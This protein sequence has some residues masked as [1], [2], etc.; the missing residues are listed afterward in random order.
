MA[1]G[2]GGGPDTARP[3]V[4]LTVLCVA[5]FMLTLDVAVA[6][7]ALPV[8]QGDLRIAIADLQWVTVAYTL[9][10]GGFLMLAGRAAD[11]VGRRRMFIAGLSLFT[12]AS[13]GCAVS[14]AD[15]HL[16]VSR[17]FQGVGAAIVTPVALSLLTT[18]FAEGAARNRAMGIW[19]ALASGG[20]IAGQVLGGLIADTLG[21][22]WIFFI[23]LP[24]GVITAGAALWV[25]AADR[26]ERRPRLDLPG[27]V[28][29]T[30]GLILLVYAISSVAGA[31]FTPLVL[32]CLTASLL[33]LAAFAVVELRSPAPLVRFGIFTNRGVAVGNAVNVV[34][35]AASG[36]VIFFT[37]LYLQKVLGFTPLTTGIAFAPVTAVILLVSTH[38]SGLM[39]RF[40]A[41]GLLVG[42]AVSNGVGLL[43][44]GAIP[45]EGGYLVNVLPGLLFVGLGAALS[46]AP[47]MIVGT[48]GV[49]DRD[50]GLA[51]GLISTSQ[52]LGGALGVAV[53]AAVAAAW[54]TAAGGEDAAA[55]VAG[56]RAGYL[57]ALVLP[58]LM[59]AAVLALRGAPAVS[60]PERDEQTE[61]AR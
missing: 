58:V 46:F 5:Q 34:N 53:F 44:F 32:G 37:A 28:T 38:I 36:T 50:Q 19:G 10:Y 8:I 30:A 1:T 43:W 2:A 12:A 60:G 4:A 54:T 52:Q 45:V 55:L 20:A 57:G 3:W 48:S 27:A 6:S 24:V 13:L 56:Y 42:G 9:T 17:A 49:Q 26:S 15:W 47:S 40:G 29:L 41:R 33:L 25:F 59:A 7:V 31:G 16:F 11:L 14:Q 61:T 21:W 51:S 39:A 23:N 18:T 22:R 35:A